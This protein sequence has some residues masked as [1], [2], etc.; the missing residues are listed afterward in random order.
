MLAPSSRQIVRFNVTILDVFSWPA[1]TGLESYHDMLLPAGTKLGPYEIIALIGK[2]GMGE[3]YR[4]RDTRLRRD[5][6]IKVLPET[7]ASGGDWKRFER[8]AQ[9]A[10]ALNHPHICAVYDVGESNGRPF[11]VMELL[12]G[13]T[14]DDYIGKKPV[15][16]TGAL[17]LAV[18]I[19]RGSL[20]GH[21]V[22]GEGCPQRR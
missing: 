12:E 2:G 13:Q 1:L 19:V 8:E 22:A 17:A 5:V 20:E 21:R 4:A 3:V 18:Q 15:E 11:L 6:A 16:V 14:L 7:I 9:A 10:S